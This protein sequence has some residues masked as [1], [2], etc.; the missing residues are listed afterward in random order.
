MRRREFIAGTATTAALSFA[1][2]AGAQTNLLQSGS[3]RL[4]IFHSIRPPE[5]LTP[6]G[7]VRLF[8]V[9]FEELSR[10]GYIEGR[11]LTVERYS[12]LGQSDRIGELAREIVTSRPDAILEFSGPFIKEVIATATDIPM[13][14][15]TGDPVAFGLTTSLARPDRNFT[16]V[17]LDAGLEI[18]AKRVQLLLEATPRVTKLGYLNAN[19][20]TPTTISNS[21]A[22]N[23]SEAARRA[24]IPTAYFVVAGRID[25]AAYERAGIFIAVTISGAK[26]DRTELEK[27]FDAIKKQGVDALIVSDSGEL[28]AYRQLIADLAV[29]SRIPAIYPF[30]EF[31]EVGGLMSYGIDLADTMRRIAQMTAKV[32]GGA[33]PSDIPF[34]RQTKYELVLN[35]KAATSLGLE[36]SAALL[37]GADE[38]LD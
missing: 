26:V 6:K 5:Q 8:E 10:A 36:F 22:G 3:K 30:R 20:T 31:V 35:Q 27:T 11:N 34:Y 15:T 2:T 21:Y 4:A 33:K 1:W 14:G 28:L 37:T 13:F 7:G 17:V 16:G 23:V 29:R 25:Q 12:A 32:L 38:V 19:P 18:W 24:G 9:Y